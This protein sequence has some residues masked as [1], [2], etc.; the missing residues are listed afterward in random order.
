MKKNNLGEQK[1]A[2]LTKGLTLV[3]VMVGMLISAICLCTALQAYIGAVSIRAKS[4]QANAA[5]AKMETDAET[6]R[7]LSKECLDPLDLE[8][9]DCKDPKNLVKVCQGNYV[10]SLMKKVVKLDLES[11]SASSSTHELS[12]KTA[13]ESSSLASPDSDLSTS[14]SFTFASSPELLPDY[15]LVRKMDTASNAPNVLKV[16]YKLTRPSRSVSYQILES[17]ALADQGPKIE[18]QITVAQLSLSVM[19]SAALLC[20]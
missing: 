9:L 4:P 13:T 18:D 14:Q 7:Q 20:P 15:R 10:Q 11:A 16:S 17:V 12:T 2:P 19:P 1:G 6:I 5:I 3:E 8:S